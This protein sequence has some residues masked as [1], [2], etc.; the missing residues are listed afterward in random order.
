V[1]V[2]EKLVPSFEI[3]LVDVAIALA[4]L[5]SAAA[6]ESAVSA[7][8][9]RLAAARDYRTWLADHPFPSGQPVAVWADALT[10]EWAVPVLAAHN[11]FPRIGILGFG[12]LALSPVQREVRARLGITD[13]SAWLCRGPGTTLVARSEQV[14]LLTRFCDEH[15]GGAPSVRL[16][17]QRG[18]MGIYELSR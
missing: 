13:V 2:L 3:V 12:A 18:I 17:A 9:S 16:L 15:M 7:H 5:L 8:E 14:P 10:Y 11:P 6:A 1:R 4:L